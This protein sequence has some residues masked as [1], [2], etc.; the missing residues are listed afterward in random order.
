[1]IFVR[2]LTGPSG[3][4]QGSLSSLNLTSSEPKILRLIPCTFVIFSSNRDSRNTKL[5]PPCPSLSKPL[6]YH[7]LGLDSFSEL[8]NLK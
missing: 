2:R 6:H 3:L 4:Y 7:L 1:M 8:L 5:C